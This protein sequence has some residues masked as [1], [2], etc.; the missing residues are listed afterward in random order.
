[1]PAPQ[2]PPSV[3]VL[4]PTYKYAR[5]LPQ[6]IESIL[7]QTYTDFELIISDDASEDGSIDVIRSYAER[8]ERIRWHVQSPNLG[9]GHNWNWCLER[10]S[11]KYIKYVFGDDFLARRDA[12]SRLV[13]LIES[14]PDI[15]IAASA[16][17]VVDEQSEPLEIWNHI[18]RSGI[19]D[20]S[21]T[22]NWSLRSNCN[23]IGEPSVVLFRKE[24]VARPFDPTFKQV[25]DW[26][27]WIDLL[28]RGHLAYT[29]EPLCAFRTHPHQQ[30][31]VN[32]RAEG[33]GSE[34]PRLL[35]RY[36]RYFVSTPA[37]AAE[38]FERLYKVRKKRVKHVDDH[39]FIDV[40]SEA[41]GKSYYQYWLGY[42]LLRPCQNAR[43]TWDK[44]VLRKPAQEANPFR[45][46]LP[47][48]DLAQAARHTFGSPL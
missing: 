22:I 2:V 19:F 27:F 13:E 45:V 33:A 26:D 8:D 5:Y 38:S 12:L 34:H 44:Y 32:R 36:L 16:R 30:T 37:H 9:I 18:G 42:K 14:S 48:K 7:S 21:E 47:L 3:S 4:L 24:F 25:L 17:I 1:M 31:E 43:R 41:L 20:G 39:M 10:A 23:L 29:E 11:G 28:Q 40:L 35:R 15:A 46:P 6:A